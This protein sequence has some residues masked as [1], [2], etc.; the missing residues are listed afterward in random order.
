MGACQSSHVAW[1]CGCRCLL[2]MVVFDD[3]HLGVCA[4]CRSFGWGRG[5]RSLL[6]CLRNYGFTH[7]NMVLL[8]LLFAAQ[9]YS[10]FSRISL[11]C[12]GIGGTVVSRRGL[13]VAYALSG[14]YGYG[15]WSDLC[16]V[17]RVC[18]RTFSCFHQGVSLGYFLL[19]LCGVRGSSVCGPSDGV[20]LWAVVSYGGFCGVCMRI[21]VF[22]LGE[23]SYC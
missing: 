15:V 14:A 19:R 12:F 6:L 8:G 18:V 1:P 9:A 22:P 3:G 17:R 7:D 13:A 23:A 11:Y 21:C 5:R 20:F 4:L 2:R 16:V 10:I